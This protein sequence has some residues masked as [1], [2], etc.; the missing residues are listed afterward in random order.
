MNHEK[1]WGIRR[2]ELCF[3]QNKPGSKVGGLEILFG[4][5]WGGVPPMICVIVPELS[6][7]PPVRQT[8][9]TTVS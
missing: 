2:P 9:A 5:G 6:T 1:K 7:R 8:E 4:G 3:A